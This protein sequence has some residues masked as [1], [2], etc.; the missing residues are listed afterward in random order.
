MG[1][2]GRY[3]VHNS[4]SG[5]VLDRRQ[6]QAHVGRSSRHWWNMLGFDVRVHHAGGRSHPGDQDCP[7]EG[8]TGLA[9]ESKGTSPTT[10]GHPRGGRLPLQRSCGGTRADGRR[11][12]HPYHSPHGFR[13]AWNSGCSLGGSL[14]QVS[15]GEGSPI[16]TTISGT[17]IRRGL[18]SCFIS[19]V[20][21]QFVSVSEGDQDI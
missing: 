12:E 18:P 16:S 9:C 7:P 1:R 21:D 4:Y 8:T 6:A 10:G 13:V 17:D 5:D 11:P 15:W 2:L 3:G 20:D 19:R 14:H